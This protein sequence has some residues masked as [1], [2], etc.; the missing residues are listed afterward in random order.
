MIRL[1]ARRKLIAE[2]IGNHRIVLET[3]IKA[4]EELEAEDRELTIAERVLLRFSQ[5]GDA[6]EAAK[7][8]ELPIQGESTLGGRA[9]KPDN[10]PTMPEMIIEALKLAE[11]QGAPGLEPNGMVSYIRGR[12]WQDAPTESVGPIA[13]RMWKRGE[14][15]K[16]GARYR[17]PSLSPQGETGAV[18]APV[19]STR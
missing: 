16:E 14:L 6:A 12:W 3:H 18:A 11:S 13:W 19:P 1:Q 10:I 4:I 2:E 5:G 7:Q 9:V 15:L 17:L 8:P